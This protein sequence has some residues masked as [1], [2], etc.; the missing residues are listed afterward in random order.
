M[1][2]VPYVCAEFRD[3]AG[4][5]VFR[6]RPEMLRTFQEV[7]DAVQQD[8]IYGML[9]ADGSIKVPETAAQQKLLEQDPMIGMAATGKTEEAETR[10]PARAGRPSGKAKPEKTEPVAEAEA[11]EADLKK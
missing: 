5:T 1:V 6:I 10:K 4:N 3:S 11:A 9:V 8:L 7:P 2:I